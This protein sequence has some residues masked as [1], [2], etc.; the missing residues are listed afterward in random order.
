MVS[1]SCFQSMPNIPLDLL[2][3]AI[4]WCSHD[5][6]LLTTIPRYVVLLLFL[7]T[8]VTLQSTRLMTLSYLHHASCARYLGVRKVVQENFKFDKHIEKKSHGCRK[9]LG[10]IKKALYWRAEKVR[11]TAS[12]SI[13]LPHLEYA[14]AAWDPNSNKDISS[15]E[16]IQVS[17]IRFIANMNYG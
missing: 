10:M 13:C 12:K 17:A 3:A 14:S 1:L 11:L 8:K 7:L 2:F 15:I 4:T 16:A 9:Q 6:S 5:K